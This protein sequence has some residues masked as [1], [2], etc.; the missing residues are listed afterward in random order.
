MRVCGARV[1]PPAGMAEMERV[2]A[3]GNGTAV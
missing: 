3:S 1:D 2:L